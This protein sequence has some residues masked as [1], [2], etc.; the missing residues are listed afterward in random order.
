M[1]QNGSKFLNVDYMD[2]LKTI[3]FSVD[4]NNGFCKNGA[5]FSPRTQKLIPKTKK[6]LSSV[7]D[8]NFPVI[9]YTDEH[10]S[11]SPEF[12][13]YPAHCLK[14]EEESVL[15]DELAFLYK[16]KNATVIPKNSTNGFFT[17]D[18]KYLGYSFDTYIITGCCTDICVYQ[19]AIT[20]KSYF[21]QNNIHKKVIVIKSMVDTFDSPEHNAEQYN[22]IF[23]NSMQSNGIEIIDDVIF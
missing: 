16:H 18:K 7:L 2:P 9:A 22:K 14:G 15:V 1:D 19:L 12:N 21:N 3:F 17:L 6:L 4:I 11:N 20:L 23:F 13:C 8:K 10:Q 5:L